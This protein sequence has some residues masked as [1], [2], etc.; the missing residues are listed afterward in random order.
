MTELLQNVSEHLEY[1][2]YA[3]EARTAE[4]FRAAHKQRYGI[5]FK[6]FNDGLLLRTYFD[7]R[8]DA[9]QLLFFAN[10]L[11]QEAVLARF[12]LGKGGLFVMEAWMPG[13]YDR[14]GFATFMDAWRQD[15]S[16]LTRSPM[17]SEVLE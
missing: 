14:T 4:G 10:S 3:I 17:A 16:T 5:L 1:L 9:H 8:A 7:T 6:A 11:N 13:T 2:G 15:A 12:L